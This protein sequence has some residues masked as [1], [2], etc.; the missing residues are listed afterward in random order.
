MKK[1]S[2]LILG[3][4]LITFTSCKKEEK[5]ETPT[6]TK[7]EVKGLT[8]VNDSTKVMW[9]GFKTSDKLAVNGTFK[10]IELKDVKTG[11]TPEE[12][13]EGVAFSIPVSSLF[14]NDP[15]G[16]RDPKLISIFF[17]AMKNTELLSGILNFR[18]NQLF[19]TLSMNDVTKQIPLEYTYENNLFSMKTTLNLNDFGA[20][21][22]LDAINKAC[23][24]LHKGPDGVSKTWDVVDIRGEVLFK[25]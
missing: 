13:L 15:T 22:A 1:I 3:L 8:I 25:N 9:T 18:D 20:Q 7:E 10:E 23:F 6:E 16:T 21:G 12:V 11:N 14:S 17:G 2:L 24:D 19:M 5:T 4:T